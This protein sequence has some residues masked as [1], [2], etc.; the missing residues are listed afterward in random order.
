MNL[1]YKEARGAV[2]DV[3]PPVCP[4]GGATRDVHPR[5]SNT[6][7]YSNACSLMCLYRSLALKCPADMSVTRQNDV[8]KSRRWR[9]SGM[10]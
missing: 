2:E 1:V 10:G 7:A 9:E 8:D 5:T 4:A 3:P 6:K